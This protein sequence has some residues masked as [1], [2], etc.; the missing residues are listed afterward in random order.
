MAG[1]KKGST[2]RDTRRFRAAM[3][4][5]LE[6]SSDKM[7]QWL[8]RVAKDDPKGAVDLVLKMAEFTTPKMSRVEHTGAE[9]AKLEI[10]H[11]LSTLGTGATKQLAEPPPIEVQAVEIPTHEIK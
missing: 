8:E 2:N 7:A 5:L 4:I 11:I 1:R 10:E 3:T 6:E 9:G